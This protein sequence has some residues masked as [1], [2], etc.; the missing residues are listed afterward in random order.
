MRIGF[1]GCGSSAQKFNHPL[2]VIAACYAD[3][4]PGVCAKTA[5]NRQIGPN[6]I[7]ASTARTCSNTCVFVVLCSFRLS[8]VIGALPAPSL[9]QKELRAS[10]ACTFSQDVILMIVVKTQPSV[11]IGAPLPISYKA[12]GLMR[13]TLVG[14]SGSRKPLLRPRRTTQRTVVIGARPA[15]LLPQNGFLASTAC[16]FSTTCVFAFICIF[17]RAFVIRVRPAPSFDQYGL[18]ASTACTF[19]RKLMLFV[20]G[21]F[22]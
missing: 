22:V 11:V 12:S 17:R 3:W 8:V 2:F 4:T 7:I 19:L 20:F 6:G 18:L 5:R 13:A 1:Q 21:C 9:H 10:T 15:P 16:T 14:Q